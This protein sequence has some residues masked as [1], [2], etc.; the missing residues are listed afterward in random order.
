M[1]LFCAGGRRQHLVSPRHDRQVNPGT[2]YSYVCS[3]V[4]DYNK[5]LLYCRDRVPCLHHL[6][7]IQ[8]T[9]EIFHI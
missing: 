4:C 3:I 7:R 6:P 1:R 9:G 2:E 5:V 8:A